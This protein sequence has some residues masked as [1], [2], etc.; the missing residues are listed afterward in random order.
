MYINSFEKNIIKKIGGVSSLKDISEENL[1]EIVN[2]YPYFGAAHFLFSKKLYQEKNPSFQ[3]QIQKTALHFSNPLW[4]Q[5]NLYIKYEDLTLKRD[6]SINDY[7]EKEADN[8]FIAAENQLSVNVEDQ[9]I[10]LDNQEELLTVKA[11]INATGT[12]AK[13]DF[14]TEEGVSTLKDEASN[15]LINTDN[16]LLTI[17]EDDNPEKIENSVGPEMEG[18]NK[19]SDLLKNQLADYEKPVDET[20]TLEL[21]PK[22]YHRVDYFASQGIKLNK[23]EETDGK[24]DI[25]VKRF[26]DWLKQMKRATPITSD[27]GTDSVSESKVQ[28]SAENSNQTEDIV[29]EAMAEVLVKQGKIEKAMEVYAKLSF[30]NT[31]KSAYFATRIQELKG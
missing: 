29:T 5:Y 11:P 14:T 17:S 28:E 31:E 27:L 23:Q 12:D 8:D 1:Q 24:L 26:T 22:Q 30:L 18:G 20:T 16:D 21:E 15:I 9:S 2:Q 19:I 13:S 4:L 3:Q 10:P 7:K 25:K 6:S